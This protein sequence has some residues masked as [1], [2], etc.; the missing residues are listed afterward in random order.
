MVS[1]NHTVANDGNDND[2]VDEYASEINRGLRASERTFS[3]N[4]IFTRD[5]EDAPTDLWYVTRYSPR[6]LE[7]TCLV[8]LL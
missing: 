2:N 5:R 7:K 3:E 6:N 4:S 1:Q 8:T